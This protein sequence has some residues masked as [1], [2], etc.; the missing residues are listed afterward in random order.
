MKQ[1]LE[2]IIHFLRGRNAGVVGLLSG[3]SLGLSLVIFGLGRTIFIL[4]LGLVGYAIGTRFFADAETFRHIL[5]RLF[6]P[7]RFR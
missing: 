1:F 2:P 7:G 3:L 4:L 5:D 6:P